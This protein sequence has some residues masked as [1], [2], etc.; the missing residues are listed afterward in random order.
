MGSM[1]FVLLFVST[2]AAAALKGRWLLFAFGLLFGPAVWAVAFLLP[3]TRRSWW[4]DHVYD[5]SRRTRASRLEPF[6][7]RS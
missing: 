7:R 1:I 4:W 2:G 3:A 5:D 6:R